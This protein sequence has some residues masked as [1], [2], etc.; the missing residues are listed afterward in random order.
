MI[1][2]S[3]LNVITLPAV[4]VELPHFATANFPPCV[5]AMTGR[6]SAGM[7]T[8]MSTWVPELGRS[9]VDVGGMLPHLS[10]LLL[11]NEM[12]WPCR[13]TGSAPTPQ[14]ASKKLCTAAGELRAPVPRFKPLVSSAP[15]KPAIFRL[16]M[17]AS[18][19]VNVGLLL[20]SSAPVMFRPHAGQAMFDSIVGASVATKAVL[21]TIA[22]PRRPSA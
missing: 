3:T 16:M 17:V 12:T 14:P 10:A 9:V 1:V 22:L 5:N 7:A 8:D 6:P 18:V 4:Q 11:A 13:Q 21:A 19:A 20:P 2:V 15:L